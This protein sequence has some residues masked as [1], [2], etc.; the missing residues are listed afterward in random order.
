MNRLG[1]YYEDMLGTK[2]GH[3]MVSIMKK[4]CWFV[5]IKPCD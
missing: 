3:W 5:A 2:L 1:L 4:N